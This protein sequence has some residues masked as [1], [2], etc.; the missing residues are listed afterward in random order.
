MTNFA[1]Q[2]YLSISNSDLVK[3]DN[4]KYL[5]SE[6]V[7]KDEMYSLMLNLLEE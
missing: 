3:S 5:L 1:A 2:A 7:S 4:G 6:P